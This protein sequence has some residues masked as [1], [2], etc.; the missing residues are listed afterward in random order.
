MEEGG[1]HDLSRSK[2]R[3]EHYDDT[4][5]DDGAQHPPT[6]KVLHLKEFKMSHKKF[7]PTCESAAFLVPSAASVFLSRDA[8]CSGA[9]WPGTTLLLSFHRLFGAGH[10]C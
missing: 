8:N 9:A 4:I 5:D 6:V 3:M 1:P 7:S 2:V 10:Q